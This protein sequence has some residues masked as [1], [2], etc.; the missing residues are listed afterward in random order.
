MLTPGPL[1]R[2]YYVYWTIMRI[3]F[4]LSFRSQ[5]IADVATEA[6]F[7]PDKIIL[8]NKEA[9]ITLKLCF[10]A[11]FRPPRQNH[12]VGRWTW[13]SLYSDWFASIALARSFGLQTRRHRDLSW[14]RLNATHSVSKSRSFRMGLFR[15]C[16]GLDS[17]ILLWN[18]VVTVVYLWAL[19]LSL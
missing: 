2:L 5:S 14:A 16:S 10:R 13:N 18:T 8:L 19:P 1:C 17:S 9:K 6:S 4:L 12:Q 11:K 7:T 3:C 15:A